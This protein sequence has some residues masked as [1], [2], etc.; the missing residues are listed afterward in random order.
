MDPYL[1]DPAL[2]PEFHGRL[3]P[4][5]HATLRAGPSA[6]YE[7]TVDLHADFAR[8]F[9]EG[10]YFA[11]IDYAYDPPVPLTDDDRRWLH[12]W[13]VALGIRR[14]T[15]PHEEVARAAYALWQEEGRPHGRD[16]EH[17]REALA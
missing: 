15:P 14:P 13:L 12:E 16:R 7:A 8:C 6:R 2:W 11:R 9:A 3:V 1:E 4:V 5:L 10:N 17:W